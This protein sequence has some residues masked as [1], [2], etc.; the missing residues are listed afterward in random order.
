M[1]N[2]K[3]KIPT[4][5]DWPTMAINQVCLI[6]S[7]GTAPIY[8]SNSSI[9]V[10]GQRCVQISGF[11]QSAA[12][13]HNETKLERVLWVKQ[14]DILLNCTIGRSCI[15]TAENNAY[16]VDGH[17]TLIRPNKEQLDG[18]WLNALLQSHYGQS[19]L[20]IYCYSGSTNQVELSK[21][22]LATSYIPLPPPSEQQHIAHILDIL[23]TQIQ[24]TEQ[25][26]GKLKQ[27]KLGLL[28][29]LLTRGIDENGEMRDPVA[30]PEKFKKSAVGNIP[31][32]WNVGKFE[33][34]ANVIDPQPS[35]RAPAEV[36]GGEPYIGVGDLRA[37]GSINFE[38]CRK[39][40][41][42]A[43]TKQ[44]Q[45]FSIEVGDII[46]GKIGTIGFPQF[47]PQGIRYALNANTV[48]IKP[49][50][51]PSYVLWLLRSSFVEK[52]IQMQI[53]STTQPAFGIQRI[54]A[55][56][57]PLP[58]KN[59]QHRISTILDSH[60]ARL[61]TEES[62]LAKLKQLKKGLMH[63]L[64]TGRVRVT[65]LIAESELLCI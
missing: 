63:D 50:H 53:H 57:V 48:L 5:I 54:R 13:P 30:H 41:P 36:V 42:K 14:G 59:E 17:V 55:M 27:I 1:P 20:E 26:I 3:L 65:S 4:P 40:S 64:L 28:H 52:Q 43:V 58:S 56:L 61:V 34:L 31:R 38:S 24:H 12:R 19:H 32:E 22:A 44:Q 60:S 7:R 6:V 46:F 39:V 33:T 18:G 47:L 23:D 35:H 49:K 10:I 16:I 2:L 45:R 21:E 9:Y 11:D 8:V 29:D 62:H 15:F 37:D 51:C 25:L